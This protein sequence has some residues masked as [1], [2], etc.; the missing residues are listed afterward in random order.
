VGASYG[1]TREG[2]GRGGIH[3]GLP[4]GKD[5]SGSRGG[6]GNLKGGGDINC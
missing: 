6:V 4:S 1:M 5:A 3:L 2:G